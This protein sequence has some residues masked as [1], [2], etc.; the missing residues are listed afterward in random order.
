MKIYMFHYV[1]KN[2][3]YYHFDADAFESIVENYSMN[4]KIIGLKEIKQAIDN[5]VELNDEYVAFTFDDGTI[6]HYKYV[7][8]ILKKYNVKG[9]FFICSNIFNNEILDIHFI[10][11]LIAK[12]DI[13][14]L[15]EDIKKY[16][17][18]KN[19]NTN[20]LKLISTQYDNEKERFVKQM[21][22]FVLP[23]NIRKECLK[24]LI[25]KYE[26]ESHFEEYYISEE[27]VKEMIE[28]GME[29]GI[30]TISHK[31]LTLM[32]KQEKQKEIGENMKIAK[33]KKILGDIC[34]LSYPF[35]SYDD[36]TIKLLEDNGIDLGF[37]IKTTS[38]NN[39]SRYEIQR[40]DANELK[41]MS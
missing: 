29:F 13:D 19:I 39:L 36:E 33:N 38:Q 21:L 24:F 30:H 31:R 11:R 34:A 8:P 7:Y 6:D 12:V 40:H 1:T 2:F 14:I 17:L 20:D 4:K 16:I 25:K 15:Y 41:E 35:G 22:Q 5:K 26:I 37:A 9:I 10:H 27:N 23:E 32:S 28:N 3:N 18:E